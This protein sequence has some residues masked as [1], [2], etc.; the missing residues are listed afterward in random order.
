MVPVSIGAADS[1]LPRPAP[2][3]LLKGT[4]GWVWSTPAP[5]HEVVQRTTLNFGRTK[6][7]SNSHK[8]IP[9]VSTHGGADYRRR[10][11]LWSSSVERPGGGV[12]LRSDPDSG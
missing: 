6:P 1:L 8:I 7:I 3:N 10:S 11:F 12:R 2:R 9:T 4:R 5:V